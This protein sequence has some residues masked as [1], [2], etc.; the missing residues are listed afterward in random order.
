[1]PYHEVKQ[2][3]SLA[4]IADVHG[5]F[6]DTLWNHPNN[7]ALRQLRE[8]P[9]VLMARDRVFIPEPK[10]KEETGET[11]KVHTFRLKGVP[12][13]LNF[14]L[15]DEEDQP[16]AGLRYTL[17]VDGKQAAAGVTPDDGL[18]SALIAP[19]AKTAE[20]VVHAPGGDEVY[21][22]DVGHLNPIEYASGVQARLKNLGLY[23]G[24][25]TGKIDEATQEALRM[26]QELEG[27]PVTG[28]ADEA[29]KQA[30]MQRHEI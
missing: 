16:R 4:L 21:P 22:F 1:M 23:E 2:G 13:R 25:L 15:L 17:S 7:A 3:E 26:F 28:Q 27:L 12:V 24:D 19:R 20:L 9:N 29:T 18:I 6:W 14:R 10:P 8:N 30:L 5:F 11:G